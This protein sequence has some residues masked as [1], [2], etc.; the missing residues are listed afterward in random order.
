[1]FTPSW[2]KYFEDEDLVEKRADN[3]KPPTSSKATPG[4]LQKEAE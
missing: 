4:A 2:T 1:M 3:D